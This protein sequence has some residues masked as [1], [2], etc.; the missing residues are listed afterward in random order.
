MARR[1]RALTRPGSPGRRRRPPLGFRPAGAAGFARPGR[2][3]AAD[4]RQDGLQRQGFP[5]RGRPLPRVPGEIRQPQG[6]RL[7]PLRPGPGDP[8]RPG[9]G[10]QRGRRGA[11]AAGRR[12]G[13]SRLSVLSLLP[14]SG[15]ARPGRQVSGPGRGHAAAGPAVEGP[16]PRPLR[17]RGQAV[18]RRPGRL[19]GPR[20]AARPRRQRSAHRPGMGSPRPLR[21][22][23]DAAAP[24]RPQGRPRGRRGLHERL[25]PRQEPLP[26]PGPLLPRLRLLPAEGRTGGRPVADGPGAVHRPRVR[27]TCP[28]FA[29]ANLSQRPH[30]QPARRGDGAIP[31]RDRR[32]R[33]AE[34]GGRRDA[35]T[36]RS[37]Q[38]RPRREGPSGSAGA[39]PAARLRGPLHV[40]PRRDAV[41]GRQIRRGADAAGGVRAAAPDLAAGRGGAAAAGLLPGAAQ[42]VRRRP[43]RRCSR[44]RTRNRG[45]P[46]RR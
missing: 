5:F 38:E 9:Q 41:R 1:L 36:T 20:Q 45:W 23:R 35:Q 13:C 3:H 43:E 15:R 28:L 12:Q 16:G 11:A 30:E 17:R 25:A 6:R 8:R 31:G 34:G 18:R 39:R 7:G 46:I 40:L 14:R 2:R 33:Q 44:W 37:L 21:P 26:R 27:R 19:F 32:L 10:L 4:Q 22:G 42:A 29:G 24:P